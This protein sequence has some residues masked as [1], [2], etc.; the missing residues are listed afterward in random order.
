MYY[1]Q[2]I[3]HENVMYLFLPNEASTDLRKMHIVINDL[4]LSSVYFQCFIK[5]TI[6]RCIKA[7]SKNLQCTFFGKKIR[8]LNNAHIFIQFSWFKIESL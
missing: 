5:H 3:N 4:W 1:S 7:V 2:E 6:R 8:S